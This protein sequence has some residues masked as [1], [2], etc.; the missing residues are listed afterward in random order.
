MTRPIFPAGV[1][2]LIQEL[3]FT[4][5]TYKHLHVPNGALGAAV[6][7]PWDLWQDKSRHGRTSIPSHP[8]PPSYTIPSLSHTTD[9]P[10]LPH[11]TPTSLPRPPLPHY[12]PTLHSHITPTLYSHTHTHTTH[13][14]TH[15][16]THPD[17]TPT[18]LPSPPSHLS[19]KTRR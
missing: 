4:D 17:Y 2:L 13:T 8:L 11:Y 6:Q 1:I 7:R 3:L 15:T 12:T 14:H 5:H 18:P 16:H 19:P 9:P 10:T